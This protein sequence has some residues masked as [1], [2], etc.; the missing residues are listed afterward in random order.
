VR[1]INDESNFCNPSHIVFYN[2]DSTTFRTRSKLL[3][4]VMN[5]VLVCLVERNISIPIYFGVPFQGVSEF[6]KKLIIYIYIYIFL[7]N[8]KLSIQINNIK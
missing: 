1:V 8:I 2:F 4:S 3:T 6:L 5:T 7:Y